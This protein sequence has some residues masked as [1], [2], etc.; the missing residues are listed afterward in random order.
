MCVCR[1]YQLSAN[2]I[3]NDKE[4]CDADDDGGGGTLH[5]LAYT[6]RDQF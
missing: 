4:Y 3:F 2:F 6:F 1:H 5:S